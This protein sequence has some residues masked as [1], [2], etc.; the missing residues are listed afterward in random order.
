M[1]EVRNFETVVVSPGKYAFT[2]LMRRHAVLMHW[3]KALVLDYLVCVVTRH[4]DPQSFSV[5]GSFKLGVGQW[6]VLVR[7]RV[8]RL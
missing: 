2:E 3:D 1:E 5:V 8:C 6:I 7:I 4:L